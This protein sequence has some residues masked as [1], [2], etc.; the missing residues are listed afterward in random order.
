MLTAL[1]IAV[2]AAASLGIFLYDRRKIKKSGAAKFEKY[3]IDQLETELIPHFATRDEAL[4]FVAK[5]Q[6]AKQKNFGPVHVIDLQVLCDNVVYRM[7]NK[8]MIP[9]RHWRNWPV[10]VEMA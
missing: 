10:L 3:L 5:F 9:E 4:S 8:G 7:C 2:V 6:D 1:L